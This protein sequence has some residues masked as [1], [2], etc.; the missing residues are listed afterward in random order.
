MNSSSTFDRVRAGRA[1]RGP[2]ALAHLAGA[3][4]LAALAMPAAAQV[5]NQPGESD[6]YRRSGENAGGRPAAVQRT[7]SLYREREGAYDKDAWK[8]AW[9]EP[10]DA[11]R[12]QTVTY[13]QASYKQG[14]HPD[15]AAYM[16][17]DRA[18]GWQ[19]DRGMQQQ[20]QPMLQPAGQQF[21]QQYQ[22]QRMNL[23]PASPEYVSEFD[24][25]GDDVLRLRGGESTQRTE[26]RTTTVSQRTA[27]PARV[28]PVSD[29]SRRRRGGAVSYGDV[30]YYSEIGYGEFSYYSDF[31]DAPH[32]PEPG[33]PGATRT[34][35]AA[36]G[37]GG[38]RVTP[39]STT[40]YQRTRTTETIYYT[41]DPDVELW[42]D[43]G[44][45]R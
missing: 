38:G 25:P 42:L 13:Q 41:D 40:E 11:S 26:A 27:E 35:T 36:T 31:E 32:F 2:A 23:P 29:D 7:G 10:G 16:R 6:L 4:V 8:R 44:A 34:P 15:D 18:L 33:E 3:A 28:T 9:D 21:D 17:G 39:A 30:N 37:P 5:T 19:G 14:K 45:G 24:R 22:Y 43:E 20:Q 1:R 12:Q